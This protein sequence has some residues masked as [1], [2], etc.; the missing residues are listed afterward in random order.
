MDWCAHT[1]RDAFGKESVILLGVSRFLK[2][3]IVSP[4]SRSRDI[5][6]NLFLCYHARRDASIS[7]IMP[8]GHTAE[9]SGQHIGG[10]CTSCLRLLL[11][12]GHDVPH[13]SQPEISARKNALPRQRPIATDVHVRSKPTGAA[14]GSAVCSQ[15]DLH[16]FP[17]AESPCHDI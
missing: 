7:S 2:K 11:L 13:A 15:S 16:Y 12:L 8:T 14:H 3:A 1:W 10:F 17:S 4:V 9:H 6:R 5:R